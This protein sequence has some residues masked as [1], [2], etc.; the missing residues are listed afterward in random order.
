MKTKTKGKP[1]T[2]TV[3][4]ER[5]ETDWWVATVRG[6]RGCHT[7]GR[8]VE[9]A[10]RRVREALVLFVED[11]E[12]AELVDDVKLP[13]DVRRT[14][15]QCERARREANDVQAKAQAL[16]QQAVRALT[17]D[18]GLSVRDASALLGLSHQRVAQLLAE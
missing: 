14:V 18:L 10:R 7:Q 12:R 4:Y 8:T 2:Y 1:A 13:A 17:R 9:E 15:T 3:T 6:V 5:D 11:A 16:T